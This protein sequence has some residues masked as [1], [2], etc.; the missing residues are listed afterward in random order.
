M[1]RKIPKLGMQAINYVGE[2]HEMKESALHI[3]LKI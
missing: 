2:L 1:A 3:R